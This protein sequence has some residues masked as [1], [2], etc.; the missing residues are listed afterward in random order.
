MG[1][2]AKGMWPAWKIAPSGEKQCNS[3]LRAVLYKPNDAKHLPPQKHILKAFTNRTFNTLPTLN[4]TSTSES[5]EFQAP[6]RAPLILPGCGAI[7]DLR[8]LAPG[9]HE[10]QLPA[11]K[12]KGPN[13]REARAV[14]PWG[15]HWDS[16]KI[17]HHGSQPKRLV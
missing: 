3:L 11:E 2:A 17:G 13:R 16:L 5:G 15:R 7:C 9:E 4:E 8:P 10:R 12:S 14:G 1:D 6:L